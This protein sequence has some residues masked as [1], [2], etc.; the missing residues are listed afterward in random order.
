VSISELDQLLEQRWRGK[1]RR[2]LT[3]QNSV[4]TCYFTPSLTSTDELTTDSEE[5]RGEK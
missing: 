4:P 1:V 5:T 2:G 3:L